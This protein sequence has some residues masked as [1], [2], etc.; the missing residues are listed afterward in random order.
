MG[1][2]PTEWKMRVIFSQV[3]RARCPQPP[4]THPATQHPLTTLVISKLLLLQ[5]IVQDEFL[6]PNFKT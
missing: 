5:R 1:V 3:A 4:H 2:G 6:F